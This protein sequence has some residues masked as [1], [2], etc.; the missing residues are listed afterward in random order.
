MPRQ[1]VPCR[2]PCSLGQNGETAIIWAAS[3]VGKTMLG[4]SL[5]MALAGGGTVGEWTAS[6]ALNVLYVDGEMHEQDIQDR[7]KC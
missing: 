7:L 4:L 3:G 5:A 6:R 1:L 2:L